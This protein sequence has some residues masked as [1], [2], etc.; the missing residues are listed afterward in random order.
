M[1]RS[2][3][4]RRWLAA[5]AARAAAPA[6]GTYVGRVPGGEAYLAVVLD[7]DRVATYLCDRGRT[8]GWFPHRAHHEGRA[9][10]RSRTR[11][12]TLALAPAPAG[13]QARLQLPDFGGPLGHPVTV[14][15][16]PGFEYCRSTGG[17]PVP[18]FPPP[19]NARLRVTRLTHRRG[20]AAPGSRVRG[21]CGSRPCSIS[22]P[23]RSTSSSRTTTSSGSTPRSR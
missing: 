5:T 11:H 15:I 7:R 22:P 8:G 16:E 10:P 9:R 18:T 14:A 2:R 6:A 4:P 17:G 21:Q 20:T 13:L 12:T 1:S 19:R 23:P 3:A